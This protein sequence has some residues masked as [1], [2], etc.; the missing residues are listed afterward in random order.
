MQIKQGGGGGEDVVGALGINASLHTFSSSSFG[1]KWQQDLKKVGG[2]GEVEALTTRILRRRTPALEDN[3]N[4]EKGNENKLG[5]R[6]DSTILTRE[7]TF[8][9]ESLISFRIQAYLPGTSGFRVLRQSLSIQPLFI[10]VQFL[11]LTFRN[12]PRP[13]YIVLAIPSSRL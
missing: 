6:N 4:S 8:N 1:F 2:E 5:D 13:S 10:C 9:L 3:V 7:S 11:T 12:G